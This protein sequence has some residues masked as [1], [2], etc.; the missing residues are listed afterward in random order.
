MKREERSAT[1]KAISDKINEH[2][3]ELITLEV[4]DSGSTIRKAKEDIYL[5]ARNMSYC[6]GSSLATTSRGEIL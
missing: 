2:Q 1:L 4:S 5:S 3:K 6:Q